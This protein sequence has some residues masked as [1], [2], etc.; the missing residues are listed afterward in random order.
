MT[1]NGPLLCDVTI[2]RVKTLR[3]RNY[4]L[5][6]VKTGTYFPKRWPKQVR[7]IHL[8]GV[9]IIYSVLFTSLRETTGAMLKAVP[10]HYH[11]S[12]SNAATGLC[13]VCVFVAP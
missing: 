2:N 8:P 1:Y 12:S 6:T 3:S 10:L 9:E 7:Q 4:T 13:C 11:L 5:E